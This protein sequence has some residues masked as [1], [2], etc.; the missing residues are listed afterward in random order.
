M[1]TPGEAATPGFKEWALLG[2]VALQ[3]LHFVEHIA[4]V[5]QKFFL[6]LPEA[7]GILGAALDTEWVHF[8]Y[9]L[10]LFA[11]LW[12]LVFAYRL[13]HRR[14]WADHS[15]WYLLAL[16]SAAILQMYHMVEHS[17]KVAQHVTTGCASCPG[18]LGTPENLVWLHF[19]INLLVLI[20]MAVAVVGL[21]L[22]DRSSA[23]TSQR[24]T[25]PSTGG[26]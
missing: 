14:S 5:T 20:P 12:G 13:P 25:V 2:A 16:L 15:R 6:G 7:H 23:W 11:V 17:L 10:A 19:F 22:V 9:N 21:V 4:Q 26:N 3:G 18:L 24:D 8:A 1:D